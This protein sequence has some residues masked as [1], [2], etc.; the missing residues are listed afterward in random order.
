MMADGTFQAARQYYL[1]LFRDMDS[2]PALTGDREGP[3][4]P[5]VSENLRYEPGTLAADRVRG[6]CAEN[7]VTENSFFI[8]AM[9]LLLG[10]YLNSD[11]AELP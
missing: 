8:S 11:T 10:K 7:Q 6:F 1:D 2:L 4:T 9:I 5:G 3:L